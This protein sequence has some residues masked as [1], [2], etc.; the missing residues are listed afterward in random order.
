MR[1][2]EAQAVIEVAEAD[3]GVAAVRVAVV[4]VVEEVGAWFALRQASTAFMNLPCYVWFSLLEPPRFLQA[5]SVSH[6]SFLAGGGRGGFRGGR[7]G[8]ASA[9]K[10]ANAGIVQEF[11]GKKTTFD[12]SD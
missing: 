8:G 12:D 10:A 5:F 6:W 4:G 2:P 9:A 3:V 1:Y 11:Q 7:G